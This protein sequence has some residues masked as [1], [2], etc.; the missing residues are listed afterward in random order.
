MKL[1]QIYAI[2]GWP[3]RIWRTRK[4]PPKAVEHNITFDEAV[5]RV[6]KKLPGRPEDLIGDRWN[7]E[8]GGLRILP[9]VAPTTDAERA[10]IEERLAMQTAMDSRYCDL[11]QKESTGKLSGAELM[12]LIGMESGCGL[13]LDNYD[14]EQRASGLRLEG[15]KLSFRLPGEKRYPLGQRP[16]LFPK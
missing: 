11:K 9:R 15:P 4:L 8:E 12:E 7:W 6:T 2:V 3:L 1:S 14:P 10:D 5:R 16:A 13:C